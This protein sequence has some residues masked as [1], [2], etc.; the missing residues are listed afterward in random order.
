M[1]VEQRIGRIDRIG[2]RELV[3]I[4]N[5]FYKDTVEEQVY[6]GIGE[7]FD[8]FEDVVGP[9]QPVLDQVERVIQ[10]LAM[11][12]PGARREQDL[13]KR[14]DD[15]RHLIQESNSAPVQLHDLEGGPSLPF[16][17]DRPAMTLREMEDVILTSPVTA[18]LLQPDAQLPGAYFLQVG[19]TWPT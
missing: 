17:S 19:P 14:V 4:S 18:Q 11:E 9:A 3:E 6:R 1:R 12:A 2:G 10:D 8:W 16:D 5:Y 13:E 7:D 15:I